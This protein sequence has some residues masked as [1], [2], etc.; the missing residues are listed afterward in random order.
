[1]E[2]PVRRL[3][4]GATGAAIAL[5]AACAAPELTVTRFDLGLAPAGAG[6][7]TN[8]YLADA[9]VLAEF[10]APAWLDSTAIVYRLAYDDASQLRSYAHSRWVAAPASLLAQRLGER[11]PAAFRP[12]GV[13]DEP[14]TPVARQLLRVELEEFSQVFDTPQKS[15]ALLRA[16]ATLFDARGQRLV[17]QRIFEVQRPAD[18]PDALGAAH[19]LR[20]AG[21]EFLADLVHWIDQAPR[22]A[23]EPS[24][25]DAR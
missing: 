19:G 2:E 13:A 17:A 5:L 25:G 6:A 3:R 7:D 15:H 16:R 18:S 24:A 8:R 23:D 11:L 22:K 10:S 9:P 4:I 1:M 20:E 12:G 21:N 14:K